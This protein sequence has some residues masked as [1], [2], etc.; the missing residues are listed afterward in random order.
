MDRTIVYASAIP[1]DTDILSPQRDAMIALGWLTQAVMGTNTGVAGLACTQTS[2]ASMS[3]VVGPG[4]LWSQEVIDETAFGSLPADLSPLMKLGILPEAA[5]TIFPLAAPTTSG[6]SVNYLIEATFQETDTDPVVLPYVNAAYPSQ[7][8]A[9]PNNDGVA[10]NTLREQTIA[11]QL[12]VGAAAATGSQTTPAVDPGY[13]G[14]YVI[15]VNYGQLAVTS[16]S[17]TP[18]ASAPFMAYT[19]PQLCSAVASLVAGSG[20]APYDIAGRA[21]GT[22]SASQLVLN[23]PMV[24]TVTFA[25]GFGG[26]VGILATAPT[27]AI[28]FTITDPSGTN[29]GTMQFAAGATSATFS[30]VASAAF[31]VASGNLTVTAPAV[32]DATAASLIFTLKG[33]A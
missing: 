16:S 15:T 17:I 2:P 28:T 21:D 32:S 24:R 13:I 23:T 5:G 31:S 29:I 8:F 26:S 1:Q 11:L 19:M 10:S 33:S 14:L 22:F 27:N 20:A 12:K 3:V 9:G 25:A 6:Y 30:S 18:Y 4:V 7:P